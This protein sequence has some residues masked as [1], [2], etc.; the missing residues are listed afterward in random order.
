MS[1]PLLPDDVCTIGH[2]RQT[3]ERVREK[4]GRFFEV[5]LDCPVEVCA[6]RDRNGHYA[7]AFAGLY[8]DFIGVT[9]PY[10]VSE[11]VELVLDTDRKP[12]DE[13]SA[14]LLKEALEFLRN[15]SS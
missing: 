5:Y 3:R 9:E 14:I 2:H 10:Q 15:S 11:R 7:K 13:C 1:L 8:D 12:V 6:E 4:I